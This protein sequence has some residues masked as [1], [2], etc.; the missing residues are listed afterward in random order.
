MPRVN[1]PVDQMSLSSY[2]APTAG[3]LKQNFT[4]GDA[5]NGHKISY[6]GRETLYFKNTNGTSTA[7]TFTVKGVPDKK[8]G[9]AVDLGPYSVPAG[10]THF[11]PPLPLE[12]F[13]QDDGCLYVDVSN[14][15]LQISA[16][17]LPAN[18]PL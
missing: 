1:V 7:R 18:V 2:T 12:G 14:A 17:R 4:A 15:E 13:L 5:A 8:L 3:S 11:V 6:T 16:Q 10:E 9:R